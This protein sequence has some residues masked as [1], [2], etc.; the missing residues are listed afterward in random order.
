MSIPST[1]T[2]YLRSLSLPAGLGFGI[3]FVYIVVGISAPFIAPYGER[4]IT[5]LSTEPWSAAHLLGTD[6]LGRD[7]LS[8]IIFGIRNT[9]AL[10]FCI[11]ALAFA[12]GGSLGLLAA[13][14]R[15][16]IDNILARL[17]DA[18]MALPQL[19]M[20][21]LVI[22]IFGGSIG[23]LVGVIALLDGTRVF[24]LCR[25]VGMNLAVMNYVE[26]SR[27]R[28]EGLLWCIGRE[29]L[30]NMTTPLLAEFGIRFCYVFLFIS[31]LSFLGLGLQPPTADLGSMVRETSGL[32]SFGDFTPLI[33]AAAIAILTIS[34]NLVIDWIQTTTSGLD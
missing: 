23:V 7:V 11:N 16:W 20:A 29:I 17:V 26:V 6:D 18:I 2:R 5:G 8:R 1:L 19:I 25:A 22:S 12:A 27:L 15:G 24:R 30:P 34:V 10:A 13:I 3:I 33:P 28:G 4:E 9:V 21:L 14:V 31:G 32:I